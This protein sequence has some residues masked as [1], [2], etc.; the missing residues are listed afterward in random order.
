MTEVGEELEEEEEEEEEEGEPE[1]EPEPRPPDVRLPKAEDPAAPTD[2]RTSF[3]D[4][5]WCAKAAREH[6]VVAHQAAARIRIG[7][8]AGQVGLQ[9]WTRGFA[10]L[11]AW[12]YGPHTR[13][14]SG[15]QPWIP[16]VTEH[17]VSRPRRGAR[18]LRRAKTPGPSSAAIG[19]C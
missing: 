16:A 10:A 8:Q 3:A 17:R 14:Y 15:L 18:C 12:G 4:R 2:V 11:D 1:G 7:L 9:P 6:G 19:P 13:G 5:S